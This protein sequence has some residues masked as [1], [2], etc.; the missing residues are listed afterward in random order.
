M[1]ESFVHVIYVSGIHLLFIKN[2]YLSLILFQINLQILFVDIE[3]R[4]ILMNELVIIQETNLLKLLY[5]L[6]SFLFI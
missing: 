1:Q 5:L 3:L 4:F 6:T 2:H